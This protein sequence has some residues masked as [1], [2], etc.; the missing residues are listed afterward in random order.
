MEKIYTFILKIMKNNLTKNNFKKF[1]NKIIN[2]IFINSIIYSIPFNPGVY[3]KKDLDKDTIGGEIIDTYFKIKNYLKQLEIIKK[4]ILTI[5]NL[6]F[7]NEFDKIKVS[8]EHYGFIKSNLIMDFKNN[9]SDTFFEK[10]YNK[11]NNISTLNIFKNFIQEYTI[12]KY[13]LFKKIDIDNNNNNNKP[14][15]LKIFQKT[16]IG[17]YKSFILEIF[18]E[19]ISIRNNLLQYLK[20]NY[21]ILSFNFM[22]DIKNN[23]DLDFLKKKESNNTDNNTDNNTNK[24]MFYKNETQSNKINEKKSFSKKINKFNLLYINNSDKESYKEIFNEKINKYYNELKTSIDNTVDS[25]E[26]YNLYNVLINNI[27]LD[28]NTLQF[29]FYYNDPYLFSKGIDIHFIINNNINDDLNYLDTNYDFYLDW[30]NKFLGQEKKVSNVL[31][32][33]DTMINFKNF[34]YNKFFELEL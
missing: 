5:L 3:F 9:L 34:F 15:F 10:N 7:K 16:Y 21:G 20:D 31:N 33:I 22:F 24:Y 19:Y 18:N 11:K 28:F 27:E 30:Y 13:N 25:S 26:E 6:S 2:D 23:L 29:I 8:R 4:F 17:K 1:K 14:Y 32:N 12:K